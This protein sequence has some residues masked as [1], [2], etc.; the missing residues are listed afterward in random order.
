MISSGVLDERRLN[1]Y[2]PLELD[3]S[4]YMLEHMYDDLGSIALDPNYNSPAQ[5]LFSM[6]RSVQNSALREKCRRTFLK[7]TTEAYRKRFWMEV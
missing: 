7:V 4:K 5:R 3:D 1:E 2:W 6:S